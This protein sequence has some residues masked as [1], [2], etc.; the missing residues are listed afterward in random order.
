MYLNRQIRRLSWEIVSSPPLLMRH[1][2]RVE[3]R[4]ESFQSVLKD[5]LYIVRPSNVLGYQSL[6]S[7]STFSLRY[8]SSLVFVSI[9]VLFNTFF[10][11]SSNYL[12]S[13]N[14]LFIH[15]FLLFVLLFCNVYI[16]STEHA[17]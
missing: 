12:C 10:K 9:F 8:H 13:L 17:I 15:I 5:H 7:L 14:L 2:R 11:F 4:V 6:L 3:K 1:R 16:P